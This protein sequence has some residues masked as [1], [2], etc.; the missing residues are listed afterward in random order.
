MD[1]A[2]VVGGLVLARPRLA[3]EHDD[4][5]PGRRTQHLA[6]DGEPEDPGSD[7]DDVTGGWGLWSVGHGRA[8]EV[9]ARRFP[10]GCGVG[11]VTV[12]EIFTPP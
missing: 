10:A 5:A 4:A 3:L 6:R 1:H 12:G 9:G 11:A 8:V 7:D 2:A